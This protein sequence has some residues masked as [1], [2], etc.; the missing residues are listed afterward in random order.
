MET[1]YF[2]DMFYVKKDEFCIQRIN[3]KNKKGR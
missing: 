1:S 2:T 3:K